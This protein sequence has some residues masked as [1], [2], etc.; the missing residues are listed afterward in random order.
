MPFCCGL[1]PPLSETAPPIQP[2]QPQELNTPKKN[3][4]SLFNLGG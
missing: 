4:R 1:L 2:Q 3:R